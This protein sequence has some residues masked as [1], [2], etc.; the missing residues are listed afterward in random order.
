M[1]MH[2]GSQLHYWCCFD[3]AAKGPEAWGEIVKIV[4]DWISKRCGKH[5]ELG[6]RSFFVALDWW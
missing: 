6:R 5:E 1:L 2:Y 4:R 3:L